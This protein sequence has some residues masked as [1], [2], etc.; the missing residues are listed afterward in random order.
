MRHGKRKYLKVDDVN[1]V[2]KKFNIE[3]IYGPAS[4]NWITFGDPN[5]YSCIPVSK[6]NISLKKK[7][8]I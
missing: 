2:F 3:R 5:N 1:A 4:P 7:P 6:H 8:A